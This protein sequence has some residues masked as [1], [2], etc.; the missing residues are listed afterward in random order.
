MTDP[1]ADDSWDELTRELGVEKSEPAPEPAEEDPAF[2]QDHADS[3]D[4]DGFDAG[5]EPEGDAPDGAEAPGDDQPGT[6]KKR[7]RRRRRRRK[8]P[9]EGEGAEAA[10]AEEGA[11]VAAAAEPEFD[12]E[13]ET[14]PGSEAELAAMPLAADEDTAGE[15][16]RDLIANWNVP[17]W[18]SI[19]T[20][21]HRPE[22]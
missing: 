12:S 10:P 11:P 18:D 20:G 22:R 6:G 1:F 7:R 16:L 21:L 5:L 14:G 19:I 8:G 9:G 4:E 3:G 13:Y 17:S 15:A 2:A